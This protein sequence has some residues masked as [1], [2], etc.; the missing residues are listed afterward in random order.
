MK[1]MTKISLLVL[2]VTLV[3]SAASGCASEAK[4]DES[5][6]SVLS[7]EE[8]ARLMREHVE[9]LRDKAYVAREYR[10]G[11]YNRTYYQD[12]NG[13]WR[14]DGFQSDV[15]SNGD[16]AGEMPS[17]SMRTDAVIYNAREA[18]EWIIVGTT[19]Y[20]MTDPGYEDNEQEVSAPISSHVSTPRE[21][22]YS[23]AGENGIWEWRVSP[24]DHARHIAETF[25][26]TSKPSGEENW[27]RYE[28]L[29]P[30]GL[31]SRRAAGPITGGPNG[32]GPF[33]ETTFE[34]S[35]V[36]DVPP[37]L[38]ELPATVNEVKS[39]EEYLKQLQDSGWVPHEDRG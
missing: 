10:D 33:S 2:A 14:V 19:A 11:Q 27:S 13:S 1:Q 38:F 32:R 31:L 29:G 35:D 28:F 7:L 26:I 25:G 18:K 15:S 21:G 37:D 12:G 9:G 16:G 17:E 6:T 30:E 23:Q 20:E 5:V 4:T 3:L 39:R 22:H 24:E 34:Y 36:G 8:G